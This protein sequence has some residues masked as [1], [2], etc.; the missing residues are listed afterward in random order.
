VG[1][2]H[3]LQIELR[4]VSSRPVPLAAT[5]S[6]TAN[7]GVWRIHRDDNGDS[8]VDGTENAL[9]FANGAGSVAS[10][11][12]FTIASAD[13]ST[14]GSASL[15]IDFAGMASSGTTRH[16]ELVAP[17][18]ATGT[19]Y[20]GS[21]LPP[22]ANLDLLHSSHSTR[23]V[24]QNGGAA[25]GDLLSRNNNPANG[26]G[27]ADTTHL[28]LDRRLNPYC[29]QLPL[30]ANPW[31]TVDSFRGVTRRDL[32]IDG[33]VVSQTDVANRLSGTSPFA[34]P[35]ISSQERKQPFEAND[36][37]PGA[38]TGGSSPHLNSIGR[39]NPSSP[40]S[41]NLHQIHFDRD[42]ASVTEL[43]NIPLRS[44][45]AL[46][47][48]VRD[49]RRPAETPAG[50]PPDQQGQLERGGFAGPFTFGAAL[51]LQSEDVNENGLLDTEDTN[52]NGVLDM[53]EDT[54]GNGILDTEDMNGNGLLDFPGGE[55]R[56]GN[57]ILDAGEDLNS[58]SMLD[59]GTSA[60]N[61]FHRL[62]SF[63]EVPTRT[64][65]QLGDPLKLTRVPGK[66]SLNGITQ[67]HVLAAL[68][69]ERA[70][71]DAPE[72][73]IISNQ[74]IDPVEDL[75]GNGQFDQGLPDRTGEPP[76]S[77]STGDLN[78]SGKID[79][80]GRD[81]WFSFLISRD[82]FDPTSG[83]PLP[84]SGVSAPFRDLGTLQPSQTSSITRSPLNDTVLRTLPTSPGGRR[85]FELGT[86]N[87]GSPA[88]DEF[89]NG[90]VD[91]TLRHR[92][93]S[94]VI[95]NST[96]RSNTFL[97]FVTIGMFE[98]VELP[99]GAVRIGGHMDVDG[100]GNPDTHRAVF[101]IDRSIAEDAFD[102]GSG[103]FDWKKLVK[104]RLRIN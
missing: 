14:V 48:I 67:P 16:D 92:L 60:P 91:P 15:Y 69:D 97:V 26:G 62:L 28:R 43:F 2:H 32:K 72:R 79:H 4:S 89:L 63:I 30:G 70:V 56:N 46:T 3:F 41:T 36:I 57:G 68:I 73:V 51:M 34:T 96:T 98:C 1:D 33:G 47:R 104:A 21:T 9:I 86:E 55:D 44:P 85:L 95:N 5:V 88:A 22:E 75:N 31:I 52:G 100:D 94:K 82:R 17:N 77:P 87:P 8:V 103:T 45:V 42:F 58:N 93:L 10:G 23:F 35:T 53:G 61:H 27:A 49:M 19:V 59:S 81:W 20:T 18:L 29:P 37:S 71:M 39:K 6:T 90:A 84:M 83:L 101:L 65:R 7:T 24:L 80:P 11:S 50:T 74:A 66:L 54:N 76:E 25:T 13:S 38:S 12:L 102:K 78:I 99:N 64:H 40:A